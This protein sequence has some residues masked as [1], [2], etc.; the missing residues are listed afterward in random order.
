MING[1]RESLGWHKLRFS[2]GDHWL[3]GP[4]RRA[5]LGSLLPVFNPFAR[6][7]AKWL[8]SGNRRGR[9]TPVGI[10]WIAVPTLAAGR[11]RVS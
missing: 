10:G 11:D 3:P 2:P 8:D 6:G 7:L 5:N 1:E 4:S 9:E